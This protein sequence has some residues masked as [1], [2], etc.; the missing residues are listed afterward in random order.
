MLNGINF[1]MDSLSLDNTTW[2]NS[3][4]GDSFKVRSNYFEDN[5]MIIQTYDNRTFPM[6]KLND[7]V[8]WQGSGNPPATP[9][10]QFHDNTT[11]NDIP[12]EVSKLINGDPTD[13]SDDS[14]AYLSDEDRALISGSGPV[15]SPLR[16]PIQ[17]QT[18][19]K[20]TNYDIIDRALSKASSPKC[21]ISLKWN[22]FP[23]REIEMLKEVM[24]IPIEEISNYYI[25]KMNGDLQDIINAWKEQISSYI[26]NKFEPDAE[27]DKQPNVRGRRKN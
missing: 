3:K 2:Y 6:S 23:Q 5:E 18:V 19:P 27:P 9:L 21:D 17:V 20:T 12:D 4:T 16:S 8:Q 15:A 24:D 26:N 13:D 1:G 10:Q 14:D 22:K 11:D 25:N 7:Y